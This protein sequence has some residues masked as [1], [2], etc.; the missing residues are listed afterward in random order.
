MFTLKTQQEYIRNT[1]DYLKLY[2]LC[3][4]YYSLVLVL[5]F[6]IQINLL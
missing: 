6:G 5:F 2:T 4:V 3:L 1:I